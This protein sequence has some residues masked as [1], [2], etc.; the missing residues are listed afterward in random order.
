MINPFYT[1]FIIAS[2]CLLNLQNAQAQTRQIEL[3]VGDSLTLG[4]C[5]QNPEY[6]YIDILIKTRWPNPDAIYNVITG[7]GFYDWFFNGD[8]DSRRLPCTFNNMKFRVAS[9]H[10]YTND[11]GSKRTV[12]FGQLINKDTVLW[13]EIEKAIQSGEVIY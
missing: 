4:P 13:I 11:D 6:E 9:F 8:I 2:A 3:K 5:N 10:T 1:L 7:E 12:V